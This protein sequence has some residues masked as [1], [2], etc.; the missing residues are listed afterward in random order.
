MREMLWDVYGVH[1]Q[2]EVT[3]TKIEKLKLEV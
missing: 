2:I 1:Y 3:H